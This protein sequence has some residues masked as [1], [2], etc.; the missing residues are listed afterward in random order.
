MPDKSIQ[1]VVKEKYGAAAKEVA[2]GKTACCGGGAELS[3]CDP[4]S[5]NLYDDT[6]EF[7]LPVNT[8]AGCACPPGC[9]DLPCCH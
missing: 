5:R 7:T 1:Q 4:I 9:V 3:G 8:A 2:A 6:K